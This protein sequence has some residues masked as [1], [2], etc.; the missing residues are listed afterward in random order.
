MKHITKHTVTLYPQDERYGSRSFSLTLSTE[1][2]NA[3]EITT[4]TSVAQ[5]AA[6]QNG[7]NFEVLSN[8]SDVPETEE[9]IAEEKAKE[10]QDKLER[11][12]KAKSRKEDLLAQ[13]IAGIDATPNGY[14]LAVEE[15]LDKILSY[16]R[17]G[18]RTLLKERN[19]YS[20]E[21]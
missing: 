9:E 5:V 17:E 4:M 1:I 12:A 6:L 3:E 8:Q 14:T 15:Q 18:I 20:L 11:E 2:F 10:E 21:T 19:L 7:W 13:V 16:E